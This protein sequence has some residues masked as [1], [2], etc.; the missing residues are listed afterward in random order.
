[1]DTCLHMFT[2]ALSSL[3]VILIRDSSMREWQ[4]MHFSFDRTVGYDFIPLYGPPLR[5]F[6]PPTSSES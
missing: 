2:L 6:P 4:L 5:S 1:M 3:H